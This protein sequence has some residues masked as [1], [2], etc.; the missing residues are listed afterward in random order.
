MCTLR[1]RG[2]DI[3][4]VAFFD[5]SSLTSIIVS[6]RAPALKST[7]PRARWS[8]PIRRM[9]CGFPVSACAS[10]VGRLMVCPCLKAL[11][12]LSISWKAATPVAEAEA[13]AMSTAPSARRFQMPWRSSSNAEVA[14]PDCL[15]QRAHELHESL[16]VA[17][18]GL[19]RHPLVRAVMAAADRAELDG[20]DAYV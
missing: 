6:E 15:R 14:L 7:A 5:G 12:T 11:T 18:E 10:S 1:S 3:R 16:A 17:G 2:I 9:V 4:A 13:S 19:D 20:R 8:A